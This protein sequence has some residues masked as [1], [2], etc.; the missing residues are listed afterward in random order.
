MALDVTSGIPCKIQAGDAARFQLSDA[1]HPAS[2]WTG[3]I[4]F[5]RGQSALSNSNASANGNL[6]DFTLNGSVTNGLMGAM[7][8]NTV[9][10]MVRFTENANSAN[11]ETG[12][13]GAI[14][15]IPNLAANRTKSQAQTMLEQLEDAIAALEGP[16]SSASFNGQSVTFEDRGRLIAYRTQLKA[17]INAEA[18]DESSALDGPDGTLFQGVFTR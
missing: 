13:R 3:T 2:L 1:E 16:F 5:A 4:Y 6:H 17:E 7:G 8:K 18:R 11:V 14:V 15:I 12:V 10:Y 9:Q